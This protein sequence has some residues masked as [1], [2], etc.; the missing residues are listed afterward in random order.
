MILKIT[1]THQPATDL[2]Y[3]LHKHPAKVQT[4]DISGGNVVV[5]YPEAKEERCTVAMLMQLD[6]IDL[7]RKLKTPG[8][9]LMLQ[10]YVN[11]RPYTASSFTS[12]AIA[13][14]FSSALNGTCKDRPELIDQPMPFEVNIPA[15][16]VS[17][18]EG[19]LEDIFEPLGYEIT[20]TQ[21]PLDEVHAEWG[22]S[23]YYSLTLKNTLTLKDLLS[24]LYVLI[25]VF[26]NN[27]HHYISR[28]EIDKL[29]NK[30]GDWL[31]HHPNKEFI[32]RRYLG[33]ISSLAKTAL[34][35]LIPEENEIEAAEKEVVEPEKKV[36]LHQVRLNAA[37]EQLKQ[38]GAKRILDLGCGEGRLIRMLLKERQFEK[39]L[40]MDVSYREL[41]KAKDRL[42]YD[43]MSPRQKERIG[44]IQGSLMYKDARLKDY[45]AA[46]VVEV[47]EHMD[48]DRL[49][50]FEQVLF[51]YI[52]P[53][54]VVITTPNSEYNVN[55]EFLE[56]DNFR[57][58]DHRFEW[59]R[60]E[61]K[62]WADKVCEQ[63]DYQVNIQMLGDVDEAVGGPSQMGVFTKK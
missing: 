50:S 22:M 26:D 5:F 39:I 12:V 59:T 6:S 53:E 1:T 11:D 36:R 37:L 29:I 61:F 25:P 44:I 60:A 40:G 20:A 62:S 54:T 23:N 38:S 7:V 13:K 52:K 47:I 35:R 46:A 56:D 18:Q 21:H 17:G 2:G 19:L 8:N 32:T 10:H 27:K 33:H 42:Y 43:Q 51:D 15:I 16:K 45:D 58:D 31:Q 28:N 49:D 63:F 57:H 9:S 14:V 41:L 3:L 55:Y 24:H 4:F 48:E 34:T 30:A